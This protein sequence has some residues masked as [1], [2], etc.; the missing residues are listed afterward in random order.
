MCFPL[1]VVANIKGLYPRCEGQL[2]FLELE[3]A[4]EIIRYIRY[5]KQSKN[6][7]RAIL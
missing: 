3:T 1:T 5:E 6:S 2:N 4:K 7:T